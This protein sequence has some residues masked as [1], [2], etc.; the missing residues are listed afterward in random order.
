MRNAGDTSFLFNIAS[1]RLEEP[2]DDEEEDIDADNQE[3]DS[4]QEDRAPINSRYSEIGIAG[5]AY[6][7]ILVDCTNEE[8]GEKALHEGGPAIKI[9]IATA[10]LGNEQVDDLSH[11]FP[12]NPEHTDIV[13]VGMQE[14]TYDI[15]TGSATSRGSVAA[16]V[17]NEVRAE[18]AKEADQADQQVPSHEGKKVVQW[19]SAGAHHL[20]ETLAR[21]LRNDF[22]L[23]DSRQVWEMR[24]RIYVHSDHAKEAEVELAQ[25]SENT[26][27]LNMG[28]NKGGIAIKFK[29]RGTSIAFVSTHLVCAPACSLL[30]SSA[31]CNFYLLS[32][33]IFLP[34]S[35]AAHEGRKKCDRRNDDVHEILSGRTRHLGPERRAQ[36]DPRLDVTQFDHCFW[37]GDMNYRLDAELMPPKENKSDPMSWDERWDHVLQLIKGQK[38]TTLLQYDELLEEIKSGRVL[39]GFQM[40]VPSFRPT[41]KVARG[42]DSS[43]KDLHEYFNNKRIPAY[44][45]RILWHSLP[46]LKEHVRPHMF[47]SCEDF[48]SSDH[49]PVVARFSVMPTAPCEVSD[50]GFVKP[51][52]N[53]PVRVF[54][55]LKFYDLKAEN[56]VASD[57]GFYVRRKIKTAS[58]SGKNVT[59]TGLSIDKSKSDPYINFLANPPELFLENQRNMVHTTY[60]TQNLNPQWKDI[61]NVALRVSSHEALTQAHITLLI[62][63]H[64]FG[65]ADDP[66]GVV[67]LA[68]K[69]VCAAADS[70]TGIFEFD[71][72]VTYFGQHKGRLRG[73]IQVNTPGPSGKF[74]H[75]DR[76]QE[77]KAFKASS[78]LGCCSSCSVS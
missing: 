62:M 1:G 47:S 43:Q 60:R 11:W 46:G 44:C 45:D 52:T 6:R 20:Y 41:F 24:L 7:D 31:H 71:R 8:S 40:V 22:V 13:V 54:P 38:W 5:D 49:K 55:Q 15:A 26:G 34:K 19:N 2:T 66:I 67:I 10:N 74:R 25:G 39:H 72:P 35:Q 77:T 4:D 32:N 70:E 28:G 57:V 58:P 68:L 3:S 64:D 48:N 53:P 16:D 61:I 23:L 56:L 37:F 51:H 36:S 29:L 27:V 17:L 59:K 76:C 18:I 30:L 42:S 14:S 73:K 21:H 50:E 63:D 78:P 75:I 12:S 9:I 33:P 65:T 69:D